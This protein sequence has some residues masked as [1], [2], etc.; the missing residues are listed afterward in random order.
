MIYFRMENLNQ[1]LRLN[2]ERE[3][4]DIVYRH[5]ITMPLLHTERCFSRTIR[6]PPEPLFP[7]WHKVAGGIGRRINHPQ[8]GNIL[9]RV[10]DERLN[11]KEHYDERKFFVSIIDDETGSPT[12]KATITSYKGNNPCQVDSSTN[13]NEYIIYHV[14]LDL[15]NLHTGARK[16][17]SELMNLA[18]E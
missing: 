16:L 17:N 10:L 5:T 11:P 6:L 2:W 4:N 14:L 8:L 1:Q 12:E 7:D 13:L 15:Y 9:L 18:G 3:L